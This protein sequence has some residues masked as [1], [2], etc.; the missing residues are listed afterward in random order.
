L[1][2]LTVHRQRG[3]CGA[4]WAQRARDRPVPPTQFP[5]QFVEE[6]LLEQPD[7]SYF[8]SDIERLNAGFTVL[9]FRV[10]NS[11]IVAVASAVLVPVYLSIKDM[12][13]STGL[14]PGL[15]N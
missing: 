3:P 10:T 5:A 11:S 14:D 6:Q 7:R 15:D 13:D 4:A 12:M 9:G 2:A 8:L 1:P